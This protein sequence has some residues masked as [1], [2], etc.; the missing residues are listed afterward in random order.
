MKLK[1]GK[2]MDKLIIIF[3][4]FVIMIFLTGC[5]KVKDENGEYVNTKFGFIEIEN[6]NQKQLLYDPET[7][8]VYIYV[9]DGY[10]AGISP[11][12]VIGKNEK[13]EIAIYGVNYNKGR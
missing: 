12:Y 1:A 6:E 11:Y 5:Q 8:V 2:Q 10:N 9:Y 3:I 13:P 4:M 7:K